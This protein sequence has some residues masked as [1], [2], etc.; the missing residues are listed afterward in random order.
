[1]DVSGMLDVAS[2]SAVMFAAM[3]YGRLADDADEAGVSVWWSICS[4]WFIATWVL[5]AA[6]AC[7]FMRSFSVGSVLTNAAVCFVGLVAIRIWSWRSSL[8][9]GDRSRRRR[10]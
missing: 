6:S 9:A 10:T 1:M 4:P 3:A 2:Y 8:K 5:A 7:L